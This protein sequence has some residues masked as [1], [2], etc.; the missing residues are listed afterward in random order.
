MRRRASD[1]GGLRARRGRARRD[2]RGA[3]ARWTH[4]GERRQAR[5]RAG[6]CQRRPGGARRAAT[7]DRC[8]EGAGA[9]AGRRRTRLHRLSAAHG[10][11]GNSVRLP[12]KARAPSSSDG[13]GTSRGRAL[14]DGGSHRNVASSTGFQRASAIATPAMRL[15]GMS[16]SRATRSTRPF[17]AGTGL[18][19]NLSTCH[20]SP[21][22]GC[23]SR[24]SSERRP[25]GSRPARRR[26]Q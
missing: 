3:P 1:A 24:R 21:N 23:S 15:I 25:A 18:P 26:E 12:K 13:A 19:I 14:V 9:W 7:G 8:G 20:P 22:S 2:A 11:A 17:R 16:C 4:A 6:P 5:H 10:L